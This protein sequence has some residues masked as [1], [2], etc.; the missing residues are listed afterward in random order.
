MKKN[1]SLGQHIIWHCV[2]FESNEYIKAVITEV[3]PDHCLAYSQGNEKWGYNDL[4]LWIDA[5]TEDDFY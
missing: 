1:F 5:D 4:K 2:D 3:H